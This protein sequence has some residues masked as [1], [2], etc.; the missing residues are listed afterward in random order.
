MDV[1][2][3]RPDDYFAE[4]LKTDQHMAKVKLRLIRQ[5]SMVKVPPLAVPEVGSRASSGA[6]DSSGW[7]G[8][9]RGEPGPLGPQPPPRVLERAA[10]KAADLPAFNHPGSRRANPNPNPNPNQA[11]C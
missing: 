8:A 1:P 7:F 4:M 3:L 9:P 6:P 2:F 11:A 5:S 10:S